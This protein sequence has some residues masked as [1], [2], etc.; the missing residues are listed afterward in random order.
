MG[1]FSNAVSQWILYKQIHYLGGKSLTT[2]SLQFYSSAKSE[3]DKVQK[4][5]TPLQRG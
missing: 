2:Q 4:Q 5:T 3:E 1:R